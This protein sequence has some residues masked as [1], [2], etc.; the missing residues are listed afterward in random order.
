M[1]FMMVASGLLSTMNLWV[2]DWKDIRWSLNDIYMTFLMTG[3]MF[4]FMGVYH[5]S[6]S[7]G[8]MGGL[9]VLLSIFSIRTQWGIHE[10]QYKTSMIPHH[11]MA[12]FMSKQLLKKQTTSKDLQSFA[13]QVIQTQE[14]EIQFLKT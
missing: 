7:M 1:F 10:K 8:S 6:I 4:F 9:M 5:R 2:N 3:W 13:K 11:S 12:V 14:Q